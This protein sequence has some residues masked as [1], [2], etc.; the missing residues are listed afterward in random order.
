[1]H[2]LMSLVGIG[3]NT[4]PSWVIIAFAGMRPSAYSAAL[5]VN[6]YVVAVIAR[7]S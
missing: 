5:V 2:V 4:F 3:Q 6:K 1:M 7:H